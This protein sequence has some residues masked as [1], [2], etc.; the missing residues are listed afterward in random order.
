ML[1]GP[2]RIQLGLP[3]T[4][5]KADAPVHVDALAASPV[6]RLAPRED[7]TCAG[8][9]VMKLEHDHSRS[10]CAAIGREES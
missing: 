2:L 8:H 6:R 3:R 7:A 4:E 1:Q 10:G 9:V 5:T